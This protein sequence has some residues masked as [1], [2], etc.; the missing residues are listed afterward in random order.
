MDSKDRRY[1]SEL[2]TVL[3][4]NI[5]YYEYMLMRYFNDTSIDLRGSWD[6]QWRNIGFDIPSDSDLLR[7]AY[8]NVIK[9]VIDSLVSKLSNQKVRPY[10]NAINGDWNTKR[11]VRN[12]QQYFDILFDNQ[13]IN[14][15]IATAFK[16]SCIMGKGYIF[17][18]PITYEITSLPAHCVSTLQC[19]ERYGKAEHALIRFLNFPTSKLAEYGIDYNGNTFKCT[20]QMYISTAEKKIA[21]LVNSAV[22]KEYK[23]DHDAL[24][25]VSLFFTSP[26][27]GTNTTSIVQELDGIQTQIDFINSQISAATQISPANQTFVIEGSNLNPKDLTNKAG[28]VYGIKMP[29]GVNTPPVVSIAPRM[30]D[31]QW[32]QMLDYYKKTAYEM[33]GVSELS[34]MSKKP[35]GLDSGVALQTMEDIESDRF[36]TQVDHYIN[37]FVDLA[38]LLIEILPDDEDIL[39]ESLNTSSLKWKDI[40]KQSDL[41]KVQY[42]AAS[43]LSKDPAEKIK[44]IMQLTQIGLITPDKVARYLDMPDLEDAYHN[45]SAVADGVSQCITRAIEEEDYSVPDWVSYENLAQEITVTQNE[46]YSSLTDDK[47]NNEK[48]FEAIKRLTMLEDSL[49]TKMEEN[50]YI[51]TQ[52]PEEAVESESGIG[53]APSAVE[54][55]DI[56]STIEENPV[57]PTDAM[58]NEPIDKVTENGVGDE[59]AQVQN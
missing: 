15:K 36:E 55:G 4:T 41:F 53:I 26:V 29:P 48:V 10:F 3:D 50:G 30:F 44:Q 33:I 18:N 23:Y 35:S 40:K 9:S 56:T 51:Q 14:K 7:S 22:A 57:E 34:S 19:E 37:A 49:A 21:L 6:A 8:M 13:K 59:L 45:A 12:V 47:K 28:T 24:P 25:L 27:F 11:T 31:P 54:A 42:S 43:S 17:V 16:L 32:Q 1:I 58:V 2:R 20:F 5:D 39:P 46:L 38:K 52:Q